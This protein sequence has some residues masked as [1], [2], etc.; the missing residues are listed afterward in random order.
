MTLNCGIS[1]QVGQRYPC[2]PESATRKI[3]RGPETFRKLE[4]GERDLSFLAAL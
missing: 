4:S 3:D 2:F 1:V